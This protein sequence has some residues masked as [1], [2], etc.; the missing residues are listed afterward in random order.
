MVLSDVE[1]GKLLSSGEL[2]VHPLLHESQ[3][4]G[5]KIDLRLD[6]QF[7]LVRHMD[8]PFYDPMWTDEEKADYTQTMSVP[9]GEP[10]YLHPGEFSVA[11]L[12]EHFHVPR[13]LMGRLEGRS[14]L[15]RIGLIVHATAGI[16]DPGYTGPI[17]L[18]LSNVGKTPIAL[19]PQM[20]VAAVTFENVEG[21]VKVDYSMRAQSKYFT[22]ITGSGSKMSLNTETDMR[23]IREI[24]DGNRKRLK[25]IEEMK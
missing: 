25:R 16:I 13:R 18:E 11:P 7:I 2:V 17:T 19:Y 23:V 12:F 24:Q 20:K 9:Y 5:A 6:N 8:R 3:I 14:S 1:L 4:H 22:D 15:G 10:F 21:E